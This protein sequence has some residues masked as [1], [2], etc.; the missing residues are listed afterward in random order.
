MVSPILPL[1]LEE[2]LNIYD[3]EKPDGVIVQF[4]GQ[5]PLTLALPLNPCGP[6]PMVFSPSSSRRSI[7]ALNSCFAEA[8]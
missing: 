3:T 5:T 6:S 7:S 8:N 4:G 2:V 1:T